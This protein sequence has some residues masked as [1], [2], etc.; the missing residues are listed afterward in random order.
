MGV[1]RAYLFDQKQG[2]PVEDWAD[3]IH[4]LAGDHV[5]WVD[6]VDASEEEAQQVGG[7]FGLPDLEERRRK[8]S[9]SVDQSGGYLAVTAVAAD[10][11]GEGSGPRAL[12]IHSLVGQNWV[13][14]LHDTEV[15]PI[16]EFRERVEGTGEVGSLDAASFLATLLEWVV[17]SYLSAFDEIETSLEDFDLTILQSPHSNA[18]QRIGVL[19]EA[20]RRI[21]MLRRALAPHREVFAALSHAEFDPVSTEE[22]AQ[23]FQELSIKVDAALGSARDAKDAVVGSFDVLIARS[24]HRMNEIMKVLTLA[25]VLLLPGALIAGVMGMNFKPSIFT[26]PWLFWVT[27]GA[28]A[29]IALLTLFAARARHWI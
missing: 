4:N 11:D 1:V 16:E 12:A 22:S 14:T 7:A 2:R 25:S 29:L 21:G 20:R 6:L 5:L 9:A 26:H 15:A 18:E 19:V 3:V 28:I 13:V 8:E 27:T 24:E 23:R 17:S 10:R